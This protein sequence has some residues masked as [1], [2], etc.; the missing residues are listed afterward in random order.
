MIMA[1]TDKTM[2]SSCKN[3]SDLAS[4]AKSDRKNLQIIKEHLASGRPKEDLHEEG[5]EFFDLVR[6]LECGCSSN[7]MSRLMRVGNGVSQFDSICVACSILDDM[8]S[9]MWHCEGGDH[10]IHYLCGKIWELYT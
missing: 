10:S 6:S 1:R 5:S 2:N 8:A 7:T 9:C 4:S 3:P